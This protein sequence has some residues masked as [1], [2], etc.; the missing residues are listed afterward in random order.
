MLQAIADYYVPASLVLLMLVAGTEISGGDLRA[1]LRFPAPVLIGAV[2]QL[3]LLPLV[4]LCLVEILPFDP[5]IEGGT[6]LLAL[7]P[8]G[9]ISNYYCY[10]ARANVLLSAS[11]ASLGTII[12][13][14]TIPAWLSA[15]PPVPGLAAGLEHM[16]AGAIIVPMVVLMLLPM[17]AGFI[18]RYLRPDLVRSYGRILRKISMGLV[19]AILLAALWDT[20]N[21]LA[22]LAPRIALAVML[23]MFA[24]MLV[25]A[26]LGF[27]MPPRDRTVLVIESGTRNIGVAL[28][29]GHLLLDKAMFEPLAGFLTAYFVI[30]LVMMLSYARIAAARMAP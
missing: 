27:Q 6:V 16:P 11:I 17:T 10:L 1:L 2:G 22:E 12:C 3:A 21:E 13:I 24:A 23:F 5:A 7:C 18:I 30:E 29:L 19:A 15:L 14:V 28:I 4:A 8:G 26:G 25:G 20:R 9:G